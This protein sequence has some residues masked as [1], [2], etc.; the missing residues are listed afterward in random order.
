M[1]S[2]QTLAHFTLVE[3]IGSGGMGEV[4]RATDAK[5]GRDV[6]LKIL[7]SELSGDPERETRFHREAR[8]LASLQHPNVASVYGFEEV[9]GI[10][11][12]VM[13]L[14]SG[15]ELTVRMKEG[16]IPVEETLD[17]ARQI[18]AGLEAAHENGIVHRDL[19]P[20]NIMET[21]DG[22]V[23]ILDFGLAQAWFGEDDTQHESATSPTMTAAM[24]QAGAILGTAAYMSP[25]QARGAG[26]DRRTDIWAFGAILFEMLTGKQLFK[27]E[28]ISDTLAAVLRKEPAWDSLPVD[29]APELCRLIERCLE[30]NP[31]QRL[32]DIG[33]ARIFLQ[34]G[35]ASISNFSFS[36]LG[37]DAAPAESARAKTP[38]PLLA[39]LALVCLSVGTV[40][41]WKIVAQ[42][43]P[44]PLLH[45]MIP[46]PKDA[47][48]DLRSPA[49]G[50]AA[51]SPDG[52]KMAFTAVDESGTSQLHLRHLDKG[53]S[54]VLSGTVGS[55]YPFWSPDSEFIGFFEPNAGK[56]KKVAAAGGPPVT[57]CTAPNGKGGSWNSR[58]EIIFAPNHNGGIF[59]VPDI[60]GA[61]VQLTTLDPDHDSHRHPRFLPGGTN[62]IFT[63]R[64]LSG[65]I[66]SIFL[67]STDTAIAP[68]I[69]SESQT[70]GD[71]VNG[72]LL[73]VHEGVLMATP[74]TPDQEKVTAGATPLVE[75]IL[76][77]QGAA[78]SVFSPSPTGMLVFQTGVSINVGQIISWVEIEKGVVEPLGEPGQVF[79]PFISPDGSQA[80][81]EV[82]NASN[83][84]TDLWLLDLATGLRTRFTFAAGDEKRPCWS[85]T[86]KDV[87][88]ESVENNSFRIMQQPV[89]GQGGAA[90]ILESDREIAPSSVDPED[91]FLLVD[92]EREDGNFELRR[93]TLEPGLD[94]MVTL[95]T[96]PDANLGGGEYSP[97][98]RWIAYHTE[99]ASG[100]DIFVIAAEGGARKWQVTTDGAVYPKWATG[101]TEL[102]VSTFSGDLRV[103]SVDGTGQTFRVGNFIQTPINIGPGPSGSF[104]DLHPDGLRVLQTGMDPAFRS[105]VSHLHLVTDWKRGLAQ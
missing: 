32:R 98:G 82:R 39:I 65:N 2:G 42:P 8:A 50:P 1:Q 17:I 22:E 97:D 10:R 99:S 85:R 57:L 16:P 102:W 21:E 30:R 37:M 19:K 67:A 31:K 52:T 13:E 90:I 94:E 104:Y 79:H 18:A 49:P 12:L 53:E 89:E 87:F 68:R 7:P 81:L 11:F 61:P 28:T 77:I 38:V 70:N 6:A 23:K 80:L 36:Q 55:A 25:E 101:G 5:L 33:E 93:I 72:N 95:A 73:T 103:Y 64:A 75:N 54:V 29:E 74:F 86:G 46:A 88:Y 48:F 47:D 40:L 24:T 96:A 58:G 34:D 9:D 105:E 44:A 63:G 59:K 91:K 56:L 83:E 26:V 69:I 43:K 100:W 45:T 62:F 66:N 35:G 71:F 27:G 60:G 15:S 84:G 41:G 3:K 76:N 51:I 78:V 92:F 4:Y 14:I 20:A